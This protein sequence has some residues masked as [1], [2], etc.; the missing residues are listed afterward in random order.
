MAS[1]T[2][3]CRQVQP[4]R[5]GRNR[6]M[7]PSRAGR[8]APMGPEAGWSCR[9]PRSSTS[10]TSKNLSEHRSRCFLPVRKGKTPFL[11][12]IPS[13]DE[14]LGKDQTSS[15]S[16]LVRFKRSREAYFMAVR[17]ADVKVALSPGSV[18]RWEFGLQP[19][20][21]GSFMAGV[22][23][24]DIEDCPS[25][26]AQLLVCRGQHQV[27]KAGTGEEAREFRLF[28]TVFDLEAELPVEAHRR[29]HVA[30]K[31]G[32]RTQAFYH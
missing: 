32:D 25:P 24:T 7:K 22:H 18:P 15:A 26:E 30:G 11:W 13:R 10:A 27:Q 23:V 31:E 28:A 12:P 21:Q 16:D 19:F 1:A 20:G 6:S 14:P 8:R 5:L 17:V 2:T 4:Y 3:I 9:P 29:S